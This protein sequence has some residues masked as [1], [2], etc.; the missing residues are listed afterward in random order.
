MAPARGSGDS[1]DVTN[2]V[3]RTRITI[4][5]S[6]VAT[7]ISVV[8]IERN[9]CFMGSAKPVSYGQPKHNAFARKA[10][11][12]EA[13]P[14]I[15]PRQQFTV[16]GIGVTKSASRRDVLPQ[17]RPIIRNHDRIAGICGIVL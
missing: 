9:I 10:E 3:A 7:I 17:A 12:R 15:E 14:A 8:K 13:A 2:R 6:V 11:F 5:L 4:A 16:G 1:I